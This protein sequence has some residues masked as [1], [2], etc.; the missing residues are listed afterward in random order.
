[1]LTILGAPPPPR[2]GEMP[3][4]ISRFGLE[5]VPVPLLPGADRPR[6]LSAPLLCSGSLFHRSVSASDRCVCGLAVPFI[7]RQAVLATLVGL[8][9][10]PLGEETHTQ[11]ASLLTAIAGAAALRTVLLPQLL[12]PAVVTELTA[13]AVDTSSLSASRRSMEVL[14]EMVRVVAGDGELRLLLL[15]A[16]DAGLCDGC[17]VRLRPCAKLLMICVRRLVRAADVSGRHGAAGGGCCYHAAAQG[18]VG[19][20]PGLGSAGAAPCERP[21]SLLRDLGSGWH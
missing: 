9:H 14:A 7:E 18:C 12:A 16:L 11:A 15:L 8:L 20:K 13:T 6:S 1:M 21:L 2:L 19:S 17:P 5:P 10:S 4:G 3:P